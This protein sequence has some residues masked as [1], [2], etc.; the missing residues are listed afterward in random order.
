MGLIFGVGGGRGGIHGRKIAL[1][2][3]VRV[4]HSHFVKRGKFMKFKQ[5]SLGSHDVRR[6]GLGFLEEE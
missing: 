2:L 4:F 5:K 6:K 1:R 3:K